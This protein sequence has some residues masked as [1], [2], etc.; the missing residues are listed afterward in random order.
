MPSARSGGVSNMWYSFN[1]GLA[2][3]VSINT[4]TDWTGAPEEHHGDSGMLPAGGFGAK[5][6]FIK[7]LENDLM[8][9]NA[10][11][12]TAMDYNLVIDLGMSMVKLSRTWKTF[13]D[14]A[15]IM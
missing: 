2:H 12:Y 6:Q 4:D 14:D 11:A 1:Y 13:E 15:S 8:K 3:Y 10:S 9:A 7:W 5:G